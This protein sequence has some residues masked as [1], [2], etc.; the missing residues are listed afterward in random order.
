MASQAL[1]QMLEFAPSFRQTQMYQTIDVYTL[2]TTALYTPPPKPFGLMGPQP[3]QFG[4]DLPELGVQYHFH[5]PDRDHLTYGKIIDYGRNTLFEQ[6]D[7]FRLAIDA[8]RFDQGG[9]KKF[10]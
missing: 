3:F 5:G 1:E 8:L 4:Y 9:F 7:S 6:K 2:G 10:P